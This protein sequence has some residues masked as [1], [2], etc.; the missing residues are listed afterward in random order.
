MQIR[1]NLNINTQ[2]AAF[3]EKVCHRKKVNK[4]EA[5]R[6]LIGTGGYILDAI[7]DGK[8]VLLEDRHGNVD[9][10]VFGF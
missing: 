3:I 6:Q 10:V 2:S 5:V 1:L 8:T 7:E 4:T 9:R